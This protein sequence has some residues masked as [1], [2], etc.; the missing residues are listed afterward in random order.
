MSYI[1]LARKWR[2]RTFSELLGQE[3]LVRALSQSLKQGRVHHA[4]LFTGT[5]GVG[6][7]SVARI[8]AKALNCEQGI[9]EQP[10]LTCDACQ[11]IEQGRFI[12]LIE[13]DAAS[14]T[15]VEDTRELLD[16]VQYAPSI[17]R[18]KIYLIDE[19]HMLSQHSFN[20]LLKTLE[21]PPPHVKFLLA[22]TDVHKLPITILSR[23][24]QFHLKHV[25]DPVI[26]GHL[27][28]ILQ[29]EHISYE[30]QALAI[31]AKEARGSMRDA[32]SL[33]DQSLAGRTENLNAA[34][35]ANL[36][37]HTT[38]DYARQL[39][40]AL[41]DHNPQQ[42]MM[43]SREIAQSNGHFR[44]VLDE[45]LSYLHRIAVV[46]T[47][48]TAPEYIEADPS[49]IR[50]GQ[51]LSAEDTQ[52]FYQIGLKGISDLPYAPTL[53]IGFEMLLLRMYTF[54][55]AINTTKPVLAYQAPALPIP[56]VISSPVILKK[57]LI[58]EELTQASITTESA[59]DSESPVQ[60]IDRT[61]TEEVVI[62]PAEPVAHASWDDVIR[63]LKL[64]GLALTAIKQTELL[65]KTTGQVRLKAEKAHQSLFTA[66]VISRIQ[67]A[68][69]AY[70]QETI[71]LTFE[72]QDIVLTSP[73]AQKKIADTQA[74]EAMSAALHSDPV[75]QQL[76]KEFSAELVKDSIS[77]I[78]H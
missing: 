12:D 65:E 41:I 39:I 70:Y 20:A 2:P 23:C 16:N 54:K 57:T 48:A 26:V 15:R 46:Q 76:Q 77:A 3:P 5:R 55:P 58:T 63:I 40:Q 1:A 74:Q 9:S 18:Y 66:P 6:K 78:D 13:I 50:F 27:Q 25:L 53:A 49:I 51:Q 67:D 56:E 10:C 29:D 36:L 73:A 35:V 38:E 68:L 60:S 37:G 45:L 52:L 19:V 64:T 59:I 32:L 17:G 22:T 33:L 30:P 34:D 28:A 7:T 24:L 14:K 75:F 47:L 43:I 11:A 72:Y 61:G 31:I 42:L 4:Y 71:R 62:P 21:E 44:Y 69:S 8:L